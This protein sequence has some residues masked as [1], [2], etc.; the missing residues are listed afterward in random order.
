MRRNAVNRKLREIS[1]GVCAPE[2]FEANGIA[3]GIT[4]EA[5]RKDLALIVAEKRCPTACVFSVRDFPSV[6]AKISKKHLKKGIARAVL[7]NSGVANLFVENGE[8]IAE[9][10]CRILARHSTV[11]VNETLL[12]STGKIGEK[13]TIEPFERGIPVIVKGLTHS[14]EGSLAAAQ[15]IMTADKEPKQAAFEFD[16]GD[17]PCKLGAIYKGS[18]RVCPNMATLIVILTTDVNI[19]SEMLQKALTAAVKDSFNL[20]NVDG[21]SSPNDTVCIMANGK[22][23]NYQ[24]FCEDTE[25]EK[26]VRALREVFIELT[27]RIVRESMKDG[28]MML[29]QVSGAKSKQIARLL[30]REVVC[31][32]AV[33]SMILSGTLNALDLVNIVNGVME[34][35]DYLKMQISV[36]AE[37][38]TFVLYRNGLVLTLHESV[39]ERFRN[40]KELK[41]SIALNDGNFGTTSYGALNG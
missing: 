28:P 3:C 36:T 9:R 29:C 12:A 10:A 8:W 16:L 26:F 41:L 40:G 25:Y 11:E 13:L 32:K 37:E 15:A 4:Q 33:H 2:G 18:A 14:E 21:V 30:A 39:A 20:M 24:I 19:S 22:A 7:V 17:F 35:T 27:K 23:G 38:E 31:S 34:E 5:E 1:G 6:T